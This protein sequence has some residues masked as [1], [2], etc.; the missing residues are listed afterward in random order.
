MAREQ[1]QELFKAPE[2]VEETA[3]ELTAALLARLPIPQDPDEAAEYAVSL[4]YRVERRLLS[5]SAEQARPEQTQFRAQQKQ[6]P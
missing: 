5:E 6:Q 3:A 2:E 4:F 1:G